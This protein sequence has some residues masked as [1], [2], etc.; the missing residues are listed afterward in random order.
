MIALESTFVPE[1]AAG[2]FARPS[3]AGAFAPAARGKRTPAG[4]ER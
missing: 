3:P 2:L 1:R 4:R